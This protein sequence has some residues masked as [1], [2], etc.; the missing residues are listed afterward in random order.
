MGLGWSLVPDGAGGGAVG[1]Q[2]LAGWE[3]PAGWSLSWGLPVSWS[4][5]PAD[6]AG[7]DWGAFSWGAGY[8]WKE[9]F[10]VGMEVTT[11]WPGTAAGTPWEVE[12]SVGGQVAADPVV[13]GLEVSAGA[14]WPGTSDP[15]SLPPWYAAVTFSAR[16]VLN[17]RALS[18]FSLVFHLVSDPGGPCWG[19]GL[20][21]SF[22]W[23]E[24]RWNAASQIT[25]SPGGRWSVSGSAAREF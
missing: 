11:P 17:D 13:V 18:G 15:Q 23:I 5:G 25:G 4:L 2:L 1:G 3:H 21:W 24:D 10:R 20:K 7:P 12:A 9:G 8:R 6:R 19:L 16:E 14:P 22:S